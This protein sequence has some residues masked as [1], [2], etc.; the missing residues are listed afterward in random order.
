MSRETSAEISSFFLR[1]RSA[2]SRT[3][4]SGGRD[5]E[6]SPVMHSVARESSCSFHSRKRSFSPLIFLVLNREMRTITLRETHENPKTRT[7]SL[8]T[9]RFFPIPLDTS[10]LIPLNPSRGT[11][12]SPYTLVHSRRVF[13]G[14]RFREVGFT[15]PRAP[16]PAYPHAPHVRKSIT[17]LRNGCRY[18]EHGRRRRPSPSART[19]PP[20]RAPASP[21]SRPRSCLAAA[22]PSRYEHR[23]CARPHRARA[24]DAARATIARARTPP[25][26]RLDRNARASPA[27]SSRRPRARAAAPDRARSENAS[28]RTDPGS[29]AC[30]VRERICPGSPRARAEAT[31]DSVGARRD[32]RRA[33]RG[34][35]RARRCARP[36]ARDPAHV[37]ARRALPARLAALYP[38][39]AVWSARARPARRTRVLSH[40]PARRKSEKTFRVFENVAVA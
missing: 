3:R 13:F 18:H 26:A 24:T 40:E 5:H 29:S 25:D 12:A 9:P 39:A 21:R 1:C 33:R 7:H 27:S 34:E 6:N 31:V 22:P 14:S 20:S 23:R 38:L 2:F 10:S 30:R 28:H 35:R 32:T 19:S 4:R 11:T 36:R 17:R 16:Q 15:T 37:R 8:S